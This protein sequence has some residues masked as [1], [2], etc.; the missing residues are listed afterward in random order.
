MRQNM[1][2]Q[3]FE[4]MAEDDL[5]GDIDQIFLDEEGDVF[6]EGIDADL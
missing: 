6:E 5:E 3:Q 4:S 2:M 1:E